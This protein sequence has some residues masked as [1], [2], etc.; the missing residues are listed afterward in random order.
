MVLLSAFKGH[1]KFIETWT[2][3]ITFDLNSH[4]CRGTDQSLLRQSLLNPAEVHVAITEGYDDAGFPPI[5]SRG[6]VS[7]FHHGTLLWN[8]VVYRICQVPGSDVPH[9]PPEG[10]GHPTLGPGI[11]DKRPYSTGVFHDENC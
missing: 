2:G 6:D 7:N 3:E 11:S 9:L 8:M 4:L 5:H 10:A 1:A